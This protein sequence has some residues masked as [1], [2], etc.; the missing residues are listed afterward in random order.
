MLVAVIRATMRMAVC[1][2][3][4]TTSGL[5]VTT[6]APAAAIPG[7]IGPDGEAL[8]VPVSGSVPGW[9]AHAVRLGSTNPSDLRR[10]RIALAPRDPGTAERL[11]H[12]VSTP[13]TRDYRRFVTSDQW[14]ELFGPDAQTIKRVR[15]WLQDSGLNVENAAPG[16][17]TVAATGTVADLEH[18]F[19]VRLD[20]YRLGTTTLVAADTD[21]EVPGGLRSAITAVLD[22]DDTQRLAEPAVATPATAERWPSPSTPHASKATS[23][24]TQ[25]ATSWSAANNSAVP[26]R[27]RSSRQSN[28]LCGYTPSQ[29]RGI[30]DLAPS[31]T[32]AGQRVGLIGAHTDQQAPADADRWAT[33]SGLQ[34]LAPGQYQT[35]STS[36]HRPSDCAVAAWALTQVQAIE[37]IRTIAPAADI[38]WYGSSDCTDVDEALERAVTAD[39]ASVLSL[40]WTAPESWYS[41]TLR[42]H[43]DQL[44]IRAAA[45]GQ[46]V[47]AATGN[48]G[49]NSH[50]T[51]HPEPTYPA[52]SPWITGVGATTVAADPTGR[53]MFTAG[54]ESAATTE[55][56]GRWSR[57]D[58]NTSFVGGASGGE[59]QVY[60]QPDYQADL[61]AAGHRS[62][63]DIAMLGDP[64]TGMR[65][66]AGMPS[67]YRSFAAGGTALAATLFAGAV[68]DALQ[69]C[70]ETD[71]TSVPTRAGLLNPTLYQ[72]YRDATV[73]SGP[74]FDVQPTAAG[75][76]TPEVSTTSVG[77]PSQQHH[78]SYLIEVD[79]RPQ[80]LR[81]APGWDPVTGLGTLTAG[82]L[83]TL[84]SEPHLNLLHW[85][86]RVGPF[87]LPDGQNWLTWLYR[88]LAIAATSPDVRPT[89][90]N[91]GARPL[92]ARPPQHATFHE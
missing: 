26:Q 47:V 41:A 11:A 64:T 81:S 31:A 4:V 9:V 54:W 21:P 37:A 85:P 55:H 79:G 28:R 48:N 5:S 78:G 30:Y 61:I 29:V 50:I 12:Q 66:G 25:C 20:R 46:T 1:L 57:T 89:G 15:G 10:I 35:A 13:G 24:A 92:A 53:P 42:N 60:K 82:S 73:H 72:L 27:Y 23:G 88:V 17:S 32:G 59:S 84:V 16:T 3:V 34:A 19:G 87:L 71:Q 8:R 38:T 6:T 83:P 91:H 65:L 40:G 7:P 36:N 51:G 90:H 56:R 76:W 58:S 33:A 52:S 69:L 45:Q 67:G 18:L 43:I 22:L 62:T 80:S 49:D 86:H 68:A 70:S 39:Q 44:L 63:P 2:A 75:I 14:R 77:K 74:I